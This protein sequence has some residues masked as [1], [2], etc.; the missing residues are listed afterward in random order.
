MGTETVCE[1]CGR[2]QWPQ[3]QGAGLCGRSHHE[4]MGAVVVSGECYRLGYA[5][6]KARAAAA[7][8]RERVQA[9]ELERHRHGDTI[10]SDGI[11]PDS[12]ALTETKKALRTL[13]VTLL[14]LYLAAEREGWE[15]GLSE[16]EVRKQAS[17]LLFN[18]GLCPGA[19][20]VAVERALGG[21]K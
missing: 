5:R 9:L 18:R 4:A 11:C 15:P 6:E 13:E 14:R 21:A 7:Q 17:A 3:A 12:L 10:E 20:P 16:D 8:E 2:K 1:V 19:H